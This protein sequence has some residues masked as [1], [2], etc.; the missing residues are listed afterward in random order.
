MRKCVLQAFGRTKR[1]G[2]ED[3]IDVVAKHTLADYGSGSKILS[4][5][6]PCYIGGHGIAAVVVLLRFRCR[7]LWYERCWLKSDQVPCDHI[8]GCRG[9]GT[10]TT[11]R[12]P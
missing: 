8:A 11:Q 12:N 9:I 5:D 2:K 6:S 4:V 10:R 1:S 7:T 3:R